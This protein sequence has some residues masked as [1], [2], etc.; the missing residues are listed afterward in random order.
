MCWRAFEAGIQQAFGELLMVMGQKE[1]AQPWFDKAHAG[2]LE[3][4]QRGGVH[5]YHHLVDFYADVRKRQR[6]SSRVGAQGY[7]A[8]RQFR[9]PG[10]ARM[11]AFSRWAI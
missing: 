11:G 5:Y 6:C 9:Q 4:A 1:R 8:T 2:Y 7:R 3:P 10:G